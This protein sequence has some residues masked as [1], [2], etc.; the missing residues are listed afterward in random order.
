MVLRTLKSQSCFNFPQV[1]MS[2]TILSTLNC[3]PAKPIQSLEMVSLSSRI[4]SFGNVWTSKCQTPTDLAKCGF[5]Y[6]GEEDRTRCYYCGIGIKNWACD[7]NPWMEHAIYSPKCSFLQ[8]NKHRCKF[9]LT[10]LHEKS[11][12]EQ[13]FVDLNEKMNEENGPT[14]Q[15]SLTY[16]VVHQNI[17]RICLV[18]EARYMLLPC[19]HLSYCIECVASLSKCAICREAPNAILKV[20]KS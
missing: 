19:R 14:T 11:D 9:T 3:V 15:D 8:L 13:L 16:E 5:Y 6:A 1:I 2:F 10:T 20:F 7:D 18:N 17:C 12:T 4:L